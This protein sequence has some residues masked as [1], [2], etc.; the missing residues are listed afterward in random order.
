M[1]RL[2]V[3]NTGMRP[4]FPVWLSESMWLQCQHLELL[5][6][7]FNN[8][9]RSLLSNPKQWE[10]FRDVDSPYQLMEQPFSTGTLD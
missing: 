2:E 6:R 3:E 10:C 8:L 5:F 9:C 1:Q 7:G 4:Q